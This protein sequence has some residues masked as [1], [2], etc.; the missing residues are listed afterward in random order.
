MMRIFYNGTDITAACCPEEAIYYDRTGKADSLELTLPFGERWISWGT[1][2]GDTLRVTRDGCD[3]G[4][5]YITAAELDSGK[6]RV[7]ATAAKPKCRK[8]GY[9]VYSGTMLR[10]CARAAGEGDSSFSCWGVEDMALGSAVRSGETPGE[11][12][13][14]LAEYAGAAL[15]TYNGAFR[16]VGVRTPQERAVIQTLRLRGEQ[17]GVRYLRRFDLG[18]AKLTV[19]TGA[20]QVSAWETEEGPGPEETVTGTPAR[21][22]ALAGVIARN[23]ILSKNRQR[24]ELTVETA[25]SPGWTALGRID[26]EGTGALGG[27]WILEEVRQDLKN[28]R[29]RGRMVRVI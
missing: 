16:M 26:T 27:Q 22:A 9:R 28:G 4:E 24:E 13:N 2:E 3:T 12:L 18:T 20:G 5:M 8:K 14:R 10:I 23:L 7:L 1:E 6:F 15:K 25:F 19:G 29:T 21:E 11:F 17:P